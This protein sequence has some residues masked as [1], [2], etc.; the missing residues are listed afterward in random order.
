[1]RLFKCSGELI[2]AESEAEAREVIRT[3]G[4]LP[5]YNS[6]TPVLEVTGAVI[7]RSLRGQ[8]EHTTAQVLLKSY[9]EGGWLCAAWV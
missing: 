4:F 3:G 6:T 1:M 8:P 5:K 2:G 9:P 7:T